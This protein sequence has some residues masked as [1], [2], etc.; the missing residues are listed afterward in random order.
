MLILKHS[1]YSVRKDLILIALLFTLYI[2][3]KEKLFTC[4]QWYYIRFKKSFSLFQITG[5]LWPMNISLYHIQTTK[6]ETYTEAL[7]SHVLVGLQ[8][9]VPLVTISSLLKKIVMRVYDVIDVV[10]QGYY[11]RYI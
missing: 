11:I 7:V 2:E 4:L 5:A 6:T 3:F 10:V 1:F 9:L 8:Q